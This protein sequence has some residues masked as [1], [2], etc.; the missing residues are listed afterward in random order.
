[1]FYNSDLY[2]NYSQAVNLSRG[3]MILAFFIK[4]IK[5]ISTNC[6]R[7]NIWKFEDAKAS[8]VVVNWRSDN[9]IN[10]QIKTRQAV[11]T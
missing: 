11:A 6:E 10:G 7:K 4:V 5:Y 8:S 1:M 2:G 3:I 9:I